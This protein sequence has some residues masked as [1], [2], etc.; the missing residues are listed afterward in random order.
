MWKAV[1]CLCF[2]T[3]FSLFFH[4]FFFFF[5]V[6][7]VL[8]LQKSRFYFKASCQAW[9]PIHGWSPEALCCMWGM[10]SS[11][12]P[13]SLRFALSNNCLSGS[14]ASSETESSSSGSTCSQSEYFLLWGS[15]KAFTSWY[16]KIFIFNG[17]SD[18]MKSTK[19]MWSAGNFSMALFS[20]PWT[21][22]VFGFHTSFGKE[23]RCEQNLFCLFDLY[24]GCGSSS[25][26]LHHFLK[27][28]QVR[29]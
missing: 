14:S 12:C 11:F 6:V 10:G 23:F 1:L 7:Y 13:I 9:F 26:D 29:V 3:L 27:K 16:L 15:Q 24:K 4:F 20:L 18:L 17:G 28:K 5:C 8:G 19:K 25:K 2:F 21:M 22:E